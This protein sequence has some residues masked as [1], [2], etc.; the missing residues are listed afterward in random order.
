M[1]TINP[2]IGGT[3]KATTLGNFIWHLSIFAVQG[4]KSE[5]K[6]PAALDYISVTIDAEVEFETYPIATGGEATINFTP[7]MSVAPLTREISIPDYL[8]ASGFIS[9]DGTFTGTWPEQLWS[10]IVQLHTL[11]IKPD[12]NPLNLQL[13]NDFR[14]DSQTSGS[15]LNATASAT[16]KLPLIQEFDAATGN[17]IISAASPMGEL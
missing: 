6:N 16:L 15:T 13:V 2:G 5:A 12:K 1:T 3:S 4:Q 17:I 7:P 11:Q 10:A 14:I 8:T 9:G